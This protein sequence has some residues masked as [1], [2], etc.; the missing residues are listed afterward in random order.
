M[1][2]Y[3]CACVVTDVLYVCYLDVSLA[4]SLVS[5]SCFRIMEWFTTTLSTEV[6]ERFIVLS[7][8]VSV[9]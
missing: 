8:F 6:Y 1:I 3:V 7:S 4:L 2:P 5:V 9:H